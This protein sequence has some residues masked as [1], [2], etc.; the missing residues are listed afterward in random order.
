MGTN[1]S[2]NLDTD[3]HIQLRELANPRSSYSL[4]GLQEASRT[5]MMQNDN[6]MM[7]MLKI[8]LHPITDKR[9]LPIR[10]HMMIA[11]IR[12]GQS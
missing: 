12:K 6:R 11:A 7:L 9:P 8:I 10:R 3:G 4:T 2:D 1:H 5:V